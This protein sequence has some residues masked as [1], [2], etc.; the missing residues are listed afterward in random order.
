MSSQLVA[1]EPY[2]QAK[3]GTLKA[4]YIKYKF[5]VAHYPSQ[6]LLLDEDSSIT[7]QEGM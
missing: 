2:I 3:V 4:T 7:L 5:P 6:Q 1:L